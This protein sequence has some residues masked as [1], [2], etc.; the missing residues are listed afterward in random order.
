MLDMKCSHQVILGSIY[1]HLV[2]HNAGTV[3]ATAF[4]VV[5][6]KFNGSHNSSP[7]L[8]PRQTNAG[9]NRFWSVPII[10]ND[11]MWMLSWASVYRKQKASQEPKSPRSTKNQKCRQQGLKT[12]QSWCF[13]DVA[14]TMRFLRSNLHPVSQEQPMFQPIRKVAV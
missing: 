6:P 13:V 9:I 2:R 8:F 5:W 10:T 11:P 14:I 4:I 7:N 3:K 1:W 12:F